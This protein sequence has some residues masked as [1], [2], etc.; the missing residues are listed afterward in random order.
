[1]HQ[2]DTQLVVASIP[3]VVRGSS[4]ITVLLLLRGSTIPCTNSSTTSYYYYYYAERFLTYNLLSS[5]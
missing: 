3:A 1:M 5:K 2:L 4:T